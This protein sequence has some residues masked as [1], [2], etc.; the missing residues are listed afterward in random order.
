M[1]FLIA[2]IINKKTEKSCFNSIYFFHMLLPS[3]P[4]TGLLYSISVNDPLDTGLLDLVKAKLKR[5]F[6]FAR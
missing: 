4:P 2:K 6:A 5:D 3:F 1:P